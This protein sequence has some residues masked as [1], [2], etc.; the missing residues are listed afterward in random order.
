MDV[1]QSGAALFGAKSE[2]KMADNEI[3]A[4]NTMLLVP[5]QSGVA[6]PGRSSL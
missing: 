6:V 5:D 3:K 4:C 1:K 2:N